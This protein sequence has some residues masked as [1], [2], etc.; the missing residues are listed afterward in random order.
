MYCLLVTFWIK[1]ATAA[2]ISS[3]VCS[4]RIWIACPAALK[5][6]LTIEPIRP[7]RK[8]AVFWPTSFSPFSKLL[9]IDFKAFVIAPI[10]APMTVPAASKLAVIV[11][12]YFLKISFT[13]SLGGMAFLSLFDLCSE[14]IALFSFCDSFLSCS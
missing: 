14:P 7:G 9:A 1:K 4:A 11:R 13:L 8:E 5:M 3:Q 6:K 10:T 2:R 12:P